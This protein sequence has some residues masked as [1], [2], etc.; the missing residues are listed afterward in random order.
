MSIPLLPGG[1]GNGRATGAYQRQNLDE[2]VC[3]P[4]QWRWL[5]ALAPRGGL[6]QVV[7]VID[8]LLEKRVNV[9]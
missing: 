2:A 9:P 7:G 1:A 3:A 4:A 8:N 6:Y 5:K